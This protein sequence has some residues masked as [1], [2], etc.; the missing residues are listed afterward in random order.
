[1]T[2]TRRRMGPV[3][4]VSAMSL[5]T[6]ACGSSGGGS[7]A[8]GCP[9]AE[10]LGPSA[11]PLG[12]LG[13]PE[14]AVLEG[15]SDA[16]GVLLAPM[17][18]NRPADESSFL[19][20]DP[21]V[22]KLVVVARSAQGL[23]ELRERTLRLLKDRGWT[24]GNSSTSG[25]DGRETLYGRSFS[26]PWASGSVVL[27]ACPGGGTSFQLTQRQIPVPPPSASRPLPPCAVFL[28]RIPAGVFDQPRQVIAGG[29]EQERDDGSLR[30]C[31]FRDEDGA[32]FDDTVIFAIQRPAVDPLRWR[33]RLGTLRDS[34]IGAAA[35]DGCGPSGEPRSAPP[36]SP[37]GA[38]VCSDDRRGRATAAGMRE[39]D[40]WAAV[41]IELGT[42]RRAQAGAAEATVLE[43]LKVALN[44]E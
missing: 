14:P 25:R 6:A 43:L 23:D 34:P 1:M 27:R 28:D 20:P 19:A 11:R 33:D 12:E 16:Q 38:V 21:D 18:G 2:A 15:L 42:D 37:P 3:L 5:L 35:R 13:F 8:G 17:R 9:G 4:A 39:N 31:R 7:D 40:F 36:G 26:G 10:A 30:F 29:D 22:P 32:S 24:A 44:L 41:T